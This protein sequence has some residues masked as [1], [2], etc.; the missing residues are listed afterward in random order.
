MSNCGIDGGTSGR[1]HAPEIFFALKLPAGTRFLTVEE[2]PYL[3]ARVVRPD[4]P[5]GR[6]ITGLFKTNLSSPAGMFLSLD[7][8]DLATLKEIWSDLPTLPLS[9]TEWEKYK[10]I[11]EVSPHRPAWGL[12][13]LIKDERRNQAIMRAGVLGEH[14]CQLKEAIRLQEIRTLSPLTHL[15]ENFTQGD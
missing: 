15:P 6:T 13:G 1:A 4:I 10:Q 9:E 14:E 7:E 3:T 2:I 12:I 8:D 11:F 5:S